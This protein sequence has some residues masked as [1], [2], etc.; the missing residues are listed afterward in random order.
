MTGCE[1]A[2]SPLRCHLPGAQQQRL[3][4]E[5]E[6]AGDDDG[7]GGRHL[8]HIV[9]ALHDLLDA[10]L[11]ILTLHVTA[12]LPVKSKLKSNIYCIYA[13]LEVVK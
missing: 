13:L 6:R 11:A 7:D 12:R 5:L 3:G 4:E 10:C 1:G 8:A 9:V 2:R